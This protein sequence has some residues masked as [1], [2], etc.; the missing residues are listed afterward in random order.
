MKHLRLLT[1][2]VM[3]LSALLVTRMG[4]THKAMA[5]YET[6]A[7]SGVSAAFYV[8][9]EPH[10]GAFFSPSGPG[11]NA[12]FTGACNACQSSGGCPS[13]WSWWGTNR[14]VLLV[15]KGNWLWG[16][17]PSCGQWN[18]SNYRATFN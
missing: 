7:S 13:S 10:Y 2:C 18:Y 5:A 11:S 15:P 14:N 12:K 3:L 17:L 9:W 4:N 16:P 8:G 1:A 6:S